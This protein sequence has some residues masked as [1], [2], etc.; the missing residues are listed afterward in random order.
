M[1]NLF[2]F[3]IIIG[4]GLMAAGLFYNNYNTKQYAEHKTNVATYKNNKEIA[5]SLVLTG[6]LAFTIGLLGQIRQRRKR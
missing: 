2:K 5:S 6:M 4:M 3:I 1:K